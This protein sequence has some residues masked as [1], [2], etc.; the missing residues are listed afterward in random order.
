MRTR[1]R[2]RELIDGSGSRP[3]KNVEITISDSKIVSIESQ[4]PSLRTPPSPA[5]K[6]GRGEGK[7]PELLID[8]GD[9]TVMPGMMDVHCHLLLEGVNVRDMYHGESSATKALRGLRNAQRTLRAGFTTLRD[10]GDIDLHFAHLAVRDAIN[11][12]WFEGPRIFAAG[13]Y[14]SITGGHGDLNDMAHEFSVPGLT[15][16]GILVDSPD[17]M[18]KAVREEVKFGAD[19]IKFF[20]T[21]GVLSAGDDPTQT[22]FSFE[23]MKTCVETAAG[24]GR[25]V[26]A[27]AHGTRGIFDA[28]RAGVRSLEHGTVLDQKTIDLMLEKKTYL[29]PTAWVMTSMA[30]GDNPM[31]LPNNSFDKAKRMAEFH[32][33]SIQKA[34]KAGIPIVTGTDVGVVPHGEN[35]KELTTLVDY[36]LTPMEAIVASTRTAAEMLEIEGE[37]G[38]LRRGMAADL[39]AMKQSPLTSIDAVGDV[40]FVMKDGRVITDRLSPKV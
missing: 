28:V 22:H 1:I 5:R 13:H 3:R 16:F 29:V 31:G 10:P 36:G 4:S 11:R 9:A 38:V 35:S 24:L 12:G 19:W 6:S 37:R 23:E 33:K 2:C 14:L 26:A 21:G 34:H 15:S 25:R 32:R 20:A 8:L 40:G 7:D 18:R 39:I 27:H 17:A 30:D